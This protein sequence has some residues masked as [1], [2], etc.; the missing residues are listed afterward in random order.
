MAASSSDRM[1]G[2]GAIGQK[3]NFADP[4]DQ[5][6]GSWVIASARHTPNDARIMV[7]AVADLPRLW[8]VATRSGM[9][10]AC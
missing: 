1:I 7:Q 8:A 6:I 10:Q 9:W 5:L 2:I 4:V 3:A